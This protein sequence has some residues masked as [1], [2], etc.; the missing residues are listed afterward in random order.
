MQPLSVDSPCPDADL[1]LGASG[2]FVF[3]ADAPTAER[4]STFDFERYVRS[5]T[6]VDNKEGNNVYDC[7][8]RR[9]VALLQ[10]LGYGAIR[11]NA[12]VSQGLR[13]SFWLQGM[14]AGFK[15]VIDCIKAFFE[16]DFTKDLEKFETL[17]EVAHLMLSRLFFSNDELEGGTMD[18]TSLLIFLAVGGVAG[19][20]VGTIMKGGG[21]GILGNIIIGIVG[22]II[23]GLLFKLLAFATG[24]LIGSIITATVGAVALLFLVKSFKKTKES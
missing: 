1:G 23:G 3:E 9:Y 16:T 2:N 6:P 4:R 10:G 11:L 24:G 14:Q 17:I 15:N 7:E 19:W 8:K 5:T 12:K 22:G 21:V 20:L 13:D 18:I